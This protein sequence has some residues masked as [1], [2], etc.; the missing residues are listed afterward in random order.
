M[1][2]AA[3]SWKPLLEGE[4]RE[5]ALGA[6]LAVAEAIGGG[7]PSAAASGPSLAAG[8]AGVALLF[9]MM[10]RA[11][12]GGRYGEL[13]LRWMER[14]IDGVA[15]SPLEPGLFSGF[16]G[17]GWVAE[18]L[19]GSLAAGGNE[20]GEAGDGEEDGDVNAALDEALARH[21][22]PAPWTFHFDLVS[23]L[24]GYGVYALARLPRPSAVAALERIVEHLS[25]LA[26]PRPGGLCWHTAPELQPEPNRKWYPYGLDN[27]GVA[28]GTPGVI[29]FLAQT[30]A[31]GVAAEKA[32]GLLRGAVSYLLRQKLEGDERS[33]YP[34]S[35]GRKVKLRA[36]RAAWC[37]G[38]PGIAAVLLAAG[39]ALGEP[40]WEREALLTARAAALRPFELCRVVDGCLCHGAAGLG[41][42]LHRLFQATGDPEIAAGARSWFR[43]TLNAWKPGRGVGGFLAYVPFEGDPETLAWQD[44]PG[45]LNGS[46]GMALALLAAASEAEPVWDRVLLL[47]P[48]QLAPG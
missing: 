22:A 43:R 25:D 16:A 41:H 44:D 21:L 46:S 5:R 6:V 33:L 28:H 4:D 10:E 20:E 39:R 17:V 27:L 9:E 1:P 19:G 12:L 42:T 35:V 11:G 32:G 40:D 37:F 8:E 13:A 34:Y 23:G 18:V 26:T 48:L 15:A 38:D 45:F 29:G 36:A 14:A 3:R 47:S 30:V 2:N 7:D 31:A 24:A